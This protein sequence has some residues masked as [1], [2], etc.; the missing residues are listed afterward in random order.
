MFVEASCLV[1]LGLHRRA[2]ELFA[3][4][5]APALPVSVKRTRTRFA[6]RE[7]LALAGAGDLDRACELIAGLLPDLGQVDSAT[8]R[9]DLRRLVGTLSRHRGHRQALV[10]LPTLYAASRPR[11]A[12]RREPSQRGTSACPAFS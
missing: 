2:A 4:D 9:T 10:L 6:V 1:D 3:A 12:S 7:T 5:P 11:A 8:V